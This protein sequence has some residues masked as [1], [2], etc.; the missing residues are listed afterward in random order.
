[1]A[2]RVVPAY[3]R[4]DNALHAENPVEQ[5]GFSHVRLAHNGH[6]DDVFLF[7]FPVLVREMGRAEIEQIARSVTVDGRHLNGIAK[8]QRVKL[9]DLRIGG[10]D[11]VAL[12]Y[13]QTDRLLLLSSMEAIS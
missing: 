4:H 8:A 11:A 6:L 3:I 5:A 12:V 9:I 13:G 7:L 2:S 10:A 1:M